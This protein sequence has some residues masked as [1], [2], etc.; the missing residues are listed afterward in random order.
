MRPCQV[1]QIDQP[2]RDFIATARVA[3]GIAK[4]L[5]ENEPAKAYLLNALDESFKILDTR[6]PFG[7]SFYASVGPAHATLQQGIAEAGPSRDVEVVA[8]GHAHIDVA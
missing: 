2:T 5:D 3:L 6:E 7:D 8:T 4:T 1:V